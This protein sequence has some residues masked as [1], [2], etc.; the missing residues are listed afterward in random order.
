MAESVTTAVMVFNATAPTKKNF[1][2]ALATSIRARITPYQVPP[3]YVVTDEVTASEASA[4]RIAA[5]DYIKYASGEIKAAKT[6]GKAIHSAICDLEH[7]LIDAPKAFSDKALA[8][9]GAW[10]RLERE[11]LANIESA[12]VKAVYE[13]DCAEEEAY[14]MA[15]EIRLEAARAVQQQAEEEGDTET[16]EEASAIAEEA[17]EIVTAPTPEPPPMQ[18][19][20]QVEAPKVEGASTAK[21]WKARVNR[22][23]QIEFFA[24]LANGR[25]PRGMVFTEAVW[26]ALDKSLTAIARNCKSDLHFLGVICWQE[27]NDRRSGRRF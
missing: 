21:T 11:R 7:D 3:D 16:A 14:L 26:E 22:E 18:M 6:F 5:D 8:A 10:R 27:E 2:V 19:P 20:E 17:E 1:L 12:R 23:K 15:A 25:I 4:A 9:V 24:A 13:H